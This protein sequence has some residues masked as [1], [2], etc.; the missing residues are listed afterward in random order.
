MRWPWPAS[1]YIDSTEAPASI[2]ER[3]IVES[4]IRSSQRFSSP[5]S[6]MP[7]T[8][9]TAGNSVAASRKDSVD[10]PVTSR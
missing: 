7:R 10:A 2:S 8:I 3:T 4:A 1:A 6:P 9:W 5:E